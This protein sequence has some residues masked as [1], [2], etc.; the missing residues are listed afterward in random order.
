MKKLILIMS[1]FFISCVSTPWKDGK[2]YYHLD[3]NFNEY[4]SL[5]IQ[6]AM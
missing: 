4:E 3:K 1:L 2:I 5:I 6:N